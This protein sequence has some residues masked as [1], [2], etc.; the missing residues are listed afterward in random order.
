[1]IEISRHLE[2]KEYGYHSHDSAKTEFLRR[3]EGDL[4]FRHG[5]AYD[6]FL[7]LDQ[8]KVQVEKSLRDIQRQMGQDRQHSKQMDMGM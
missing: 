8:S 1:M 5:L 2:N 4:L 6:A 3:R 7:D